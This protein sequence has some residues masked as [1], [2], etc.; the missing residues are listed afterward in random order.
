VRSIIDE[1]RVHQ[2]HIFLSNGAE[3]EARIGENELDRLNSI[4]TLSPETRPVFTVVDDVDAFIALRAPE[5]MMVK[6]SRQTI[7]IEPDGSRIQRTDNAFYLSSGAVLVLGNLLADQIT[8]EGVD[9]AQPLEDMFR[10][11][12]EGNWY[13][14]LFDLSTLENRIVVHPHHVH[15]LI[16]NRDLV[17]RCVFFNDDDDDDDKDEAG[18]RPQDLQ[19]SGSPD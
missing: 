10:I 1:I 6:S 8:P 15:A 18:M 2:V 14:D 7:E 12:G 17:N 19:I 11:L 5:I 3:I 16:I 4:V 9:D 13:D